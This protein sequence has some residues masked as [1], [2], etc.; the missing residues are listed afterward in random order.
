VHDDY[1]AINV[2][3]QRDDPLSILSFYKQVLK[4]RK[5]HRGLFVFGTF[6]LLDPGCEAVFA[7]VK[8]NSKRPGETAV[9]V[10]NMSREVQV[11][12]H[13]VDA[14]GGDTPQLLVSTISESPGEL[15]D[16]R[17]ILAAWEGRVYVH[18]GDE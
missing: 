4:L 3:Q 1:R 5:E 11:G 10:L 14:M 6:E 8:K 15:E 2:S 7:Y 13:V 17:P 12:P 16:G 18:C 9:V